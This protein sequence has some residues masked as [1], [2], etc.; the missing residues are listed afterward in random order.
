MK[1]NYNHRTFE[2]KINKRSCF[3]FQKTILFIH[4]INSFPTVSRH[5]ILQKQQLLH[6]L[7]EQPLST[8]V[9]F[10]MKHFSTILLTLCFSL[11]ALFAF[12]QVVNDECSGAIPLNVN[13]DSVGCDYSGSTDLATVSAYPAGCCGTVLND[14]WYSFTATAPNQTISVYNITKSYFPQY[15]AAGMM[16][17]FSGSCNNLQLVRHQYMSNNQSA[18]FANL[19]DRKSVV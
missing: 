5:Y 1:H 16:D 12:S 15:Y 4:L 17:V 7:G 10:P 6:L 13:Q 19:T 2:M 8:S 11:S 3:L 18:Y 9:L 14:V